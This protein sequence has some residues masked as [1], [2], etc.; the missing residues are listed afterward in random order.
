MEGLYVDG[1]QEWHKLEDGKT[2]IK[3]TQDVQSILDAN[4]SARSNQTS[5]WKGDWHSVAEIPTLIWGD[6]H[7][8]FGG[9]PMAKENRMRLIAKLNSRDWCKL[10]TKEGNL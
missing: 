8:E 4:Q 9:D 5:N 1:L 3:T 6:W 10:R 7:R 2:L